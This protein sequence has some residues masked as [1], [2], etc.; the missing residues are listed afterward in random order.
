MRNKKILREELF[1]L[2][3]FFFLELSNYSS[4]DKIC[5]KKKTLPAFFPITS[6]L[7]KLEIKILTVQWQK[8]NSTV[9]MNRVL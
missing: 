9:K 1:N 7:H 2:V 8:K 4:P 5:W 6:A 3:N